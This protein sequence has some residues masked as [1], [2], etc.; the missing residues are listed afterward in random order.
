MDA[1]KPNHLYYYVSVA[2]GS[3]RALAA[4]PYYTHAAAVADIDRVREAAYR[5]D[6]RVWWYAWGTAGSDR[7]LD[8]VLG[9]PEDIK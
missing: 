2:D 6:A 5:R 8:T 1:V 7:N 3:R 9:R 4:G